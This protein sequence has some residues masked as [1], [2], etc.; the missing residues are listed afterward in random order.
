[1][2]AK[3]FLSVCMLFSAACSESRLKEP[4]GT[5]YMLFYM[6]GQSNMDGYGFNSELPDDLKAP[7]TD[8]MIFNGNA[9]PDGEAGGGDGAWLPLQPGFGTGYLSSN[10]APKLSDRFGPEL[11]FGHH[12]KNLYPDEK[13]AIVKFAK[14]GSSLSL[15]APNYGTWDPEYDAKNGR[16]QFDNFLTTLN[17]AMAVSDIDGDGLKDRLI[18]TGIIWMQGESDAIE[19]EPA[20]IYEANLKQTMGRIRTAM[21]A[22]N[23]PVVIGK[24][25][26]SGM[27]EDGL[28]MDHIALVQAAQAQFVSKDNC[29]VFVSEIDD[30]VHSDDQWHYDSE[31]YLKMGT[32]FADAVS[33]LINRCGSGQSGED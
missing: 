14:G 5:D 25:T 20:M 15:D 18:P 28:V 33:T 24:I 9:V 30:Y 12:L 26:D 22:E 19:R 2:D 11:T 16:N 1:M 21:Q 3:F 6:G 7:V 27:D 10:G 17:G 4:A 23:L 8:V 31:S 13:I 29:A 32:A